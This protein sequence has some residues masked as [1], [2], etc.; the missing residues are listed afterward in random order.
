MHDIIL[1]RKLKVFLFSAFFFLCDSSL[2][3]SIF[4]LKFLTLP[5]HVFYKS[6][7]LPRVSQ[8]QAKALN[9]SKDFPNTV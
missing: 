4:H 9:A 6:L 7:F 1:L 2:L 5:L 8:T 3:L